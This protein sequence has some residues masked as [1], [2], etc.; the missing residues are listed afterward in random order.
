MKS[1]QVDERLVLHSRVWHFRALL[2]L[3]YTQL[4]AAATTLYKS[5]AGLL[6]FIQDRTRAPPPLRHTSLFAEKEIN[7]EI[8]PN[9]GT[10]TDSEIGPR[11]IVRPF[12]LR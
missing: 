11:E 9:P 5:A 10:Q 7:R 8:Q 2:L 3:A 1:F 12:Q 4:L 6:N